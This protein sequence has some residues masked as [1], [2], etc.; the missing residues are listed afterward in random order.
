M[1][2][3]E[4]QG[5]R[6]SLTEKTTLW[7]LC[8]SN[9]SRTLTARRFKQR[10]IWA[11]QTAISFRIRF[12][13]TLRACVLET[14]QLEYINYS[15][16]M[17]QTIVI[18]STISRCKSSYSSKWQLITPIHIHRSKPRKASKLIRILMEWMISQKPRI[19]WFCSTMT[20]AQ[21]P[22]GRTAC[23]TT[24][25]HLKKEANW[26]ELAHQCQAISSKTKATRNW[27]RSNSFSNR[28][29]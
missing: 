26:A 22:H 13:R 8:S 16:K 17:N 25:T 24:N 1:Q 21:I 4:F 10:E 5:N 7:A 18:S 15:N 28:I 14:I 3:L 6:S 12:P 9:Q 19:I 29:F 27:P 2:W 11:R 23:S 20:A